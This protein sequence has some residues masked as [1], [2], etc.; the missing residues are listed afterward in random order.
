MTVPNCMR[1][2]RSHVEA[3]GSARIQTERAGQAHECRW[4]PQANMQG[5]TGRGG[6]DRCACHP[7]WQRAWCPLGEGLQMRKAGD[8]FDLGQR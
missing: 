8:H 7:E 5:R 2:I 1:P 3:D 4:H 6:H